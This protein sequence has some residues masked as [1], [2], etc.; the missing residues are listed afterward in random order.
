MVLR[1]VVVAATVAEEGSDDDD[2][3]KDGGKGH[4]AAGGKA[5]ADKKAGGGGKPGAGG[6][7][8]GGGGGKGAKAGELSMKDKIKAQVEENQ[9][10][11]EVQKITG[12][13]N[14]ASGLKSLDAR[15]AKLDSEME[16]VGDASAIPALLLL[17]DW[18]MEAW[19]IAKPKGDMQPAVKVFVLIHDIY[20]R[21]KQYLQADDFKRV[22]TALIMIGFEEAAARLSKQ[23]V[24]E[25]EGRVDAA[26]VKVD[27]RSSAFPPTLIGLS[28]NR[29]Q[30]EYCGP[31]MLRNVDSAPDDRVTKCQSARALH[32]A[33]PRSR[34]FFFLSF[35]SFCFLFRLALFV[36]SIPINGSAI[37]WTWPTPAS[38]P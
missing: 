23:F 27:L 38:P 3:K 11:K 24:S 17:L 19:K 6:G 30:L 36:Q 22:S 37:C 34:D 25:S 10:L 26:A 1:E 14:V 18:C 13:I 16:Q 35:C 12:K 5:K 28:Y 31:Y 9:R 21:F 32:P 8:K 7:K 4:K 29:F 20:R 33:G 2:E 15:I